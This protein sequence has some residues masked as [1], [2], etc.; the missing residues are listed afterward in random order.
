MALKRCDRFRFD[1]FL[2]SCSSE[3]LGKRIEQLMRMAERENT[4]YEK[5]RSAMDESRRKV[6]REGVDG[7]A[8]G[9]KVR[10]VGRV[11]ESPSKQ[12]AR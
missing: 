3:N 12:E 4:E 5:K 11:D 8:V 2:R 7:E 9:R 1:Y 10:R 6:R